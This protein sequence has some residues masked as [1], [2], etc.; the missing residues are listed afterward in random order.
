MVNVVA[1]SD[2]LDPRPPYMREVRLVKGEGSDIQASGY[3]ESSV[4]ETECEALRAQ[5]RST[6]WLVY[7]QKLLVNG[8]S[9]PFGAI[10]CRV[11]VLLPCQWG[12]DRARIMRRRRSSRAESVSLHVQQ[13]PFASATAYF[14]GGLE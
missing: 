2:E 4:P 14:I 8:D 13:S 11:I 12:R 10:V 5:T 3:D 7:R 6:M 9:E 1:R